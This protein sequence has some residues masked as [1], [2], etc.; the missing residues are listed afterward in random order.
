M[1][2]NQNFF[3]KTQLNITG[4]GC[5][6]VWTPVFF[7]PG[8]IPA[9]EITESQ[10]QIS[11]RRGGTSGKENTVYLN[12]N[13]QVLVLLFFFWWCLLVCH[14]CLW[15]FFLLSTHLVVV[16]NYYSFPFVFRSSCTSSWETR[17]L[18]T[19][20]PRFGNSSALRRFY[21]LKVYTIIKERGKN[22]VLHKNTSHLEH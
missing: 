10:C 13:P 12:S 17:I 16:S 19:S 18:V 7:N 15:V 22:Q 9:S 1:Q 6:V 3:L 5:V 4:R 14:L 21:L 11:T 20:S 2:I 8:I